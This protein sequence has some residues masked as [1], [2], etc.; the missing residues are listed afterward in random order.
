MHPVPDP[1]REPDRLSSPPMLRPVGLPRLVS[2]SLGGP[3]ARPWLGIVLV[4]ATLLA[5]ALGHA[6][7]PAPEAAPS[8]T[9]PGSPAS[10][11][12]W[13]TIVGASLGVVFGAL[14]AAWQIRGMKRDA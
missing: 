8:S 11:A 14:L 9:D 10:G 6:A 13:T 3:S 2:P 7:D 4:A 12:N 1:L 5:P